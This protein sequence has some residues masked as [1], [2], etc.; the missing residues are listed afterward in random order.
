MQYT[1]INDRYSLYPQQ[2][3]YKEIVE[4][5]RDNDFTARL[6]EDNVYLEHLDLYV[7]GIVDQ[8]GEVVAWSTEDYET[9]R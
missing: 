7:A 6:K 9:Y 4:M 5:C 1:I 3:S 8:N 2:G